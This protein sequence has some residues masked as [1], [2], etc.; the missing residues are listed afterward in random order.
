MDFSAQAS[1]RPAPYTAKHPVPTVQEYRQH[2]AEAAE[3]NQQQLQGRETGPDDKRDNAPAESI[4]AEEEKNEDSPYPSTNRNWADRPQME[5]SE[6]RDVDLRSTPASGPLPSYWRDKNMRKRK[7]IRHDAGYEVTDPVTHLP[8]TAHDMTKKE[9]QAARENEPAPGST[10]RSSTKSD[11]GDRFRRKLEDDQEELGRGYR[12]MRKMFP[13]PAGGALEEELVA[14]YNRAVTVG[15][16]GVVAIVVVGVAVTVAVQGTFGAGRSSSWLGFWSWLIPT[17]ILS[18]TAAA[19]YLHYTQSSGWLE[20]K[21]NEIFKDETWIA[22]RQE[23]EKINESEAELPESVAWMNSMMSSVWPLIN[24]DLFTSL[25]DTLE[26]VMQASLPKVIRMVSID[27][28]GQGSEAI[29]ILGIKWLPTAAAAQS[30][31]SG[32]RLRDEKNKDLGAAT[33]DGQIGDTRTANGNVDTTDEKEDE[34]ESGGAGEEMEAE[35][36]DFINMELAFSYRARASGRTIKTKARNAHLYLKFYLPG[37][38]AVPVWVEVRGIVGIMRMRMQ[39]TPDPPFFSLCTVTFLG[40][41]RVDLS[42]VP[43]SKHSPNIM[44]VPLISNFVQSSVDAALAEYV[45]PKSLA[46]DLKEMLMGDDSKKDTV[47]TGVI[48]IYIKYA[49]KFKQGDGDIGPLQGGSDT[50]VTVGWGKFGKPAASTRIIVDTLTPTWDEWASILVTPEEMDAEETLRLQI[51]DSD[52]YTADDDL[53]RLEVPLKDLVHGEQTRNR[54]C[55]REDGLRGDDPDEKMPG[56]LTWSVGYFAKTMIQQD[57][58]DNQT[59][60]PD[61]RTTADLE[62]WATDSAA[63]K[64]RESGSAG[65]ESDERRQ[66]TREDFQEKELEML[67]R[68]PPPKDFRSGVLSVQIHNITGLEISKLNKHS[69]R[70]DEDQGDETVD[71]DSLPDSYCTI[72]LNHRKVYQ[73]R[74]KPKN[75][76]PFFN[77]GTEKFVADWQTGEVIISVR[78]R[79]DHEDDPLLGV[80]YLPLRKVFEQDCQVMQSFPIAGGIGYGRARISMVWR[81]VECKLPM[82]IVGWDYGTVEVEAPI[83]V[84]GGVMETIKGCSIHLRTHIT[85]GKMKASPD[86]DTWRPKRRS[87]SS[88]FLAVAKRYRTPLT[89][90]FHQ[91]SVTKQSTPAFAVL[92]LGD[93]PDEEEKQVSLKIWKGG[94]DQVARARSCAHYNGLEDGEEPLGEMEVTVKFWRGISGYHKKYASNSRNAH[95]RNVMEVLD[96]VEGENLMGD[97]DGDVEDSDSD[98]S[99][100]GESRGDQSSSE[101]RKM[102]R[103]ADTASSNS[104]TEDRED[105]TPLKS[106]PSRVKQQ[107]LCGDS[108]T[109]DDGRRGV[110]A[111]IHDY[112]ANHKQLHRKHRGIMQWKATRTLD[113][114]AGKAN[115]GKGRIAEVVKHGEKDTGIE[116]EV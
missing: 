84:K 25:A 98:S 33:G 75:A 94:K 60:H 64:L 63:S 71:E 32:G 42:C 82:E 14:V 47:S 67:T 96:T 104:D 22:A 103:K 101:K 111:Q 56:T 73:T 13:P 2:H 102:L 4:S 21:V 66:Q 5:T 28:L 44:D 62:K 29:R 61:I 45:A 78:D 93:V 51:W 108:R 18:S 77:A 30:V 88:V 31:D 92:W 115:R 46:L 74:T 106:L 70:D 99:L 54:L 19:A 76:K 12:G 24:P 15:L 26:D 43:L 48:L 95:V 52:K 107:A 7:T 59:V 81:S 11:G 27:D 68:T 113:W 1:K 65:Q 49:R 110:R 112:K 16:A 79:R 20:N 34:S 3:R 57:Q 50:Y 40:Q 91:P 97:G 90:E 109:G 85:K 100:S 6:Q 37:G 8:I 36:G 17:V 83:K 80:I 35:E 86:D 87:Q 89:F 38:I 69:T 58:L 39:L 72:I 9:L 10:T 114:M 53:G 105:K 23:E 41:P 116:T 55:D